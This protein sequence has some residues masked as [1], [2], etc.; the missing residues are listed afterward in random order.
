VI[1]PATRRIE[2]INPAFA[3][4]AGYDESELIGIDP[5]SLMEG[6]NSPV[7]GGGLLGQLRSGAASSVRTEAVMRTKAGEPVFVDIVALLVENEGGEQRLV[8]TIEDRTARV[9]ADHAQRMEAV[10]RFA[11]S[12]AH[13]FNN[14]ITVMA[15]H[16]AMLAEDT[17]EDDPGREDLR[18]I[19]AAADKATALTRQLLAFSRN[20]SMTTQI[21]DLSTVVRG[22]RRLLQSMAGD[23]AEIVLE[24]EESLGP[25]SADPTQLEQVLMNLVVNARDAMPE[26]GRILIQTKAAE[27]AA[28]G[29]RLLGAPDG[30]YVALTV[31]DTGVG[32]DTATISRIFEPF[33]TTKDV[34][35]GTG[36]GLATVYGIVQQTGGDIAVESV[37][38]EGTAFTVYL[39]LAVTEPLLRPA[40]SA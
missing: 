24:L 27:L 30:S 32:M 1:D 26:G 22:V 8:G 23:R 28:G 14:L 13:D 17:P 29:E 39:P 34:Q 12:V 40:G 15:G 18:A 37:P 19:A 9:R 33:F 6:D 36:L 11:G 38:G 4:I 7:I 10:G 35:R 5:K 31:A 3:R 16:A 2:S 20:Q 21:V 25:I